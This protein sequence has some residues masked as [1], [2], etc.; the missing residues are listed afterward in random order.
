MKIL[1]GVQGTGNGHITRALAMAKAF[2]ARPDMEVDF[3]VS[4]R[5]K[6]A[7]FDMEA[8]GDFA[9][10]PGLSFAMR[11]G[12]VSIL[13]TLSQNP[14]WQFWQ[15]VRDLDLSGYD[16]V[17]TD[18][19]PV[20][21]W[22]AKRQGVRCIG[23]GRQ[24]AFL[25]GAPELPVN[26][27]QRAMM[28]QFAPCNLAVGTHWTRSQDTFVPPIIAHAGVPSDTQSDSFERGHFLV[29]LPFEPLAQ[30]HQLLQSLT[31]YRFSVF[32]PHSQ[33]AERGHCTYYPPSRSHFAEIFAQVEG[34]ISNAGFETSSEALALGKKLLVKPLRGQFEQY[35]NANCLAEQK[36]AAMMFDLDVDY[37]ATWLRHA[38]SVQV[39][40]PDIA[41]DLVSWLA[42]GAEEPVAALSARLWKGFEPQRQ[43]VA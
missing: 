35:A 19:E 39:H 3:L 16:L 18:F 6:N 12:R 14:W 22:A 36:L 4:G 26:T 8:L 15:D 17:V 13:D 21:A 31:G 7:F 43:A 5:D 41:P 20:T 1:Y 11:D 27:L 2:K 37:T 30:V 38:D 28:K 24:Y 34:V 9:W 25:Q 33:Y 32:H 10:R 29:Y 40:W 23:L 42:N